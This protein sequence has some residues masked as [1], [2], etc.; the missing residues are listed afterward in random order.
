MK[1]V[2]KNKTTC[3]CCGVETV[4]YCSDCAIMTVRDA[5]RRLHCSVD[6]IRRMIRDGRLNPISRVYRRVLIRREDVEA[7]LGR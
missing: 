7:M 1:C 4:P 3:P 6:T 2:H 5:G